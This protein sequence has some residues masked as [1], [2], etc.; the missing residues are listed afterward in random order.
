MLQLF[1]DQRA[2]HGLRLQGFYGVVDHRFLPDEQFGRLLQLPALDQDGFFGLATAH[3]FAQRG[4]QVAATMRR[5]EKAPATLRNQENVLLLQLDVL[6]VA[7]I[8]AAVAAALRAFGR[9]DVL[10]NNA[11]YAL[12]GAFEALSPEQ[13]QQ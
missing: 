7:S 2:D 11:G 10:F 1:E 4:W 6:D 8:E 9:L 13:V 12:A 5:P 3:Y